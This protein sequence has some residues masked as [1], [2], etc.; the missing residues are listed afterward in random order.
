M[1]QIKLHRKIHILPTILFSLV[2]VISVIFTFINKISLYLIIPSLFIYSFIKDPRLAFKFKPL[3][4]FLVYILW[5][6]ITTVASINLSRSINELVLITSI[7]TL[8]YI[9]VYFSIYNRKYIYLFYILYIFRFFALLYKSYTLGFYSI[10]IESERFNASEIN[11]N[12]LGYF[13]YFA[14]ISSFFLLNFSFK[15][16]DFSNKRKIYLLLFIIVALCALIGVFYAASRGGMLIILTTF[17]LLLTFRYIYPFSRKTIIS[18]IVI[19]IIIGFILPKGIKYY[20]GSYLEK[21]F[22]S[23]VEL[24]E[25]TRVQ[26]LE[27]ALEIGKKEPFFGVGPGNFL[28]YTHTGNNSHSTFFEILANNGFIG[29]LIFINII[30]YYAE[31]NRK[32]YKLKNIRDRKSAYFFFIFLITFIIYNF[33]YVFHTSLFLMAYFFIVSIHLELFTRSRLLN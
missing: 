11:A 4:L 3:K 21:R 30:I 7:F 32:L 18:I 8:S 13:G 20:N 29:L 2:F 16:F 12:M 22:S 24:K 15:K 31:K 26:L 14:I 28:L 23:V 5:S 19:T 9:L 10:E 33:F 1:S 25:E 27:R 6:L 17:I